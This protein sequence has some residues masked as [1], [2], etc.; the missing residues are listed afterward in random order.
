MHIFR[1]LLYNHWDFYWFDCFDGLD[2]LGEFSMSFSSVTGLTQIV[3]RDT[4]RINKAVKA[5]GNSTKKN[6]QKDKGPKKG[7][8]KNKKGMNVIQ[9]IILWE[10]TGYFSR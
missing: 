2:V 10:S 8:L 3:Q 9:F 1:F 5:Y 6:V 4:K 7:I